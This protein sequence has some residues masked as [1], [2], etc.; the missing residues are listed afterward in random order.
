MLL[1]YLSIRIT[2]V[3]VSMRG[4]RNLG[5]FL[6]VM[7]NVCR[8]RDLCRQLSLLEISVCN[9]LTSGPTLT[10]GI[11]LLNTWFTWDI[12]PRL[13]T[14]VPVVFGHRIPIVIA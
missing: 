3:V 5:L 7:V 13:S 6:N 1:I 10:F 12:R 8:D 2:G 14:R 11:S 4:I 9:L